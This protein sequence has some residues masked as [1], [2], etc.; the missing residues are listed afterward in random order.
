MEG[1]W[2]GF[3]LINFSFPRKEKFFAF[4]ASV[5]LSNNKEMLKQMLTNKIEPSVNN[6]NKKCRNKDYHKKKN[7]PLASKKTSSKTN[8]NK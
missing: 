3:S 8:T 4:F 6:M 5:S 1:W 2:M 7:H